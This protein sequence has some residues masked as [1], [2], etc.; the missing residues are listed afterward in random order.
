MATAVHKGILVCAGV[1]VLGGGLAGM[2]LAN[3]T[4]TGAFDFY[5]QTPPPGSY[6]M[7]ATADSAGYYPVSRA[8][9]PSPYPENPAPP[10]PAPIVRPAE[11]DD[12]ALAA[13]ID[14]EPVTVE[15]EAL[16]EPVSVI[17]VQRGSWTA[18]AEEEAAAPEPEAAPGAATS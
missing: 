9:P 15:E 13:R 14:P 1:A 18:P 11:P 5:K 16:P 12:Y 7:T 10:R 2:G 6:D 17:P 8:A 4:R 3:Y